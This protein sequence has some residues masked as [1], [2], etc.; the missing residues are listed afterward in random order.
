MSGG[1]GGPWDHTVAK[2]MI[3]WNY[4]HHNIMPAVRPLAVYLGPFC[5]F[6]DNLN[7]ITRLFMSRGPRGRVD[8]YICRYVIEYVINSVETNQ[9]LKFMTGAA[10]SQ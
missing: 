3:V 4:K 10:R 6:W 8:N 9:K 1:P 2:I 5:C 7:L